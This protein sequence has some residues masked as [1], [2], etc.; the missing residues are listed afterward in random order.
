M[1]Q[2]HF[3]WLSASYED[4]QAL[5]RV[6]RELV[7]TGRLTWAGLYRDALG[8][9]PGAGYED[10]FRAGRIGRKSAAMIY[11]YLSDRF[12][13]TARELETSLRPE[14]PVA[15]GHTWRRFLIR[16]RD[17]G[18]V[19]V[20][21]LPDGP[22]SVVDFAPTDPI[23]DVEL[24][25]GQRFCFSLDVPFGGA[26]TA[27]QHHG[28]HWH[29][30]KLSRDGRAAEVKEGMQFLPQDEA[31]VPLALVEYDDAGVHEFVFLLGTAD[32]LASLPEPEDGL[33]LRKDLLDAAAARVASM[34]GWRLYQVNV[35]LRRITG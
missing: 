13:D 35:M 4:R 15:P 32:T 11:R 26:V 24:S 28:G 18:A 27:L 8:T 22:L 30:M 14:P 12:P 21:P 3:D 7:G 5:Y 9:S 31:G 17:L 34:D 16:H 23:A 33:P 2:D 25:L 10:N 20:I 1:T 29:R 19:Q 6:I